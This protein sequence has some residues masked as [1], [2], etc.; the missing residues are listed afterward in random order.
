MIDPTNN[1]LFF[2]N[3][4]CKINQNNYKYNN[5]IKFDGFIIYKYY[6]N[7]YIFIFIYIN[8]FS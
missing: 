4:I 3:I 1:N 2:D 7:I 8:I 5:Y 6:Y